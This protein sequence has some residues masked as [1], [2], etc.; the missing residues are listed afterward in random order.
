MVKGLVEVLKSNEK[1]LEFVQS[2]L[3]SASDIYKKGGHV[4]MLYRDQVFRMHF[5]NR[6]LLD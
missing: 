3:R 6:R 2:R 1:T 5:D 4:T